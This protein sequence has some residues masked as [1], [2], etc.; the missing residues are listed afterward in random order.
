MAITGIVLGAI[1][2]VVQCTIVPVALL[3]PALSAAREQARAIACKSNLKQAGLAMLMYQNDNG[4]EFPLT[5]QSL[6]SEGYAKDARIFACPSKASGDAVRYDDVDATMSYVY[7][8]PLKRAQDVAEAAPMMWDKNVHRTVQKRGANVL[9]ED[10]YVENMEV[11]E[12][13]RLVEKMA[14]RYELA[15]ILP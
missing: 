10:G 11:D 15:P 4:G 8:R 14:S 12:L 9:F 1:G 2:M 3:F 7:A 6:V 13:K 5:V